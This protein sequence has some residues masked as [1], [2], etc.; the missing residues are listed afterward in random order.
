MDITFYVIYYLKTGNIEQI[1]GINYKDNNKK[2]G[3]LFN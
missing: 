1:N 2:C 3:K